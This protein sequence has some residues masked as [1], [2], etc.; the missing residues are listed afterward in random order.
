MSSLGLFA[1]ARYSVYG[2]GSAGHSGA[3]AG[4]NYFAGFTVLEPTPYTLFVE[5]GSYFF[6]GPGFDGMMGYGLYLDQSGV[7]QPGDYSFGSGE[8]G[9]GSSGHGTG[10]G[11]T[12][13]WTV[14]A[15]GSAALGVMALALFARRRR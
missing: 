11:F 4:Y 8:S 15:P 7:L 14:P 10:G 1:D 3:M 12:I 6:S 5:A 9:T 2:A 13:R